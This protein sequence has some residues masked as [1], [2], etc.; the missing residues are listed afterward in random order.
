MMFKK[1]EGWYLV[2]KPLFVWMSR[3][4][5]FPYIDVFYYHYCKSSRLNY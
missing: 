1:L 2:D 3:S 4:R 5:C